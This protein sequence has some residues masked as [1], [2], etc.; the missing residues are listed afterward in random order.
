[1]RLTNQNKGNKVQNIEVIHEV[2]PASSVAE[3]N[4]GQKILKLL[5]L[6]KI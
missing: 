3:S 4:T 2:K 5:L 6:I 1:M